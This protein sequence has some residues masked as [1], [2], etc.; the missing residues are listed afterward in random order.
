MLG[1]PGGPP[2][3][4]FGG[5]GGPPG[6]LGGPGGP[7][8]TP[9]AP[10]CPPELTNCR[11]SP[12]ENVPP[13]KEA[14][15]SIRCQ[16]KRDS[17]PWSPSRTMVTLGTRVWGVS[18][19]R[20]ADVIALRRA[21]KSFPLVCSLISDMFTPSNELVPKRELRIAGSEE[22][23]THKNMSTPLSNRK[24]PLLARR[25]AVSV[26]TRGSSMLS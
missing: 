14:L 17:R 23:P 25:S 21:A 15:S 24:M 3:I 6:I 5:P 26:S 4:L 11:K 9:G 8:E 18:S 13:L 16:K 2:G 12:Y 1:G 19:S 20:K 22:L 7:L 10:P